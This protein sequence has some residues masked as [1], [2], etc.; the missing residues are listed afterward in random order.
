M[1]SL[2]FDLTAEIKKVNLLIYPFINSIGSSVIFIIREKIGKPNSI[3]AKYGCSDAA[4][5]DTFI[6][7]G[8]RFE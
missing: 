5:L 1:G 4:L 6:C 2:N 3:I 8:V 7:K